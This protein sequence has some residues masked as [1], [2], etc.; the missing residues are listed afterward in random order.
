[1]AEQNRTEQRSCWL[2]NLSVF[3]TLQLWLKTVGSH[4]CSLTAHLTDINRKSWQGWMRAHI[5]IVNAVWTEAKMYITAPNAEN[6][7]NQALLI[8]E[9]ELY[10]CAHKSMWQT[11]KRSKYLFNSCAHLQSGF[12]DVSGES[13]WCVHVKKR[14][15]QNT[16]WCEIY[17]GNSKLKLKS[18]SEISECKW[19]LTLFEFAYCTPFFPLHISSSLWL[20]YCLTVLCPS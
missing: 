8:C 11:V 16:L 13:W 10:L 1:M 9:P 5:F 18:K 14:T 19:V 4:C 15:V 2:P 20:L 6:K 7:Y 3:L 17:H 12:V